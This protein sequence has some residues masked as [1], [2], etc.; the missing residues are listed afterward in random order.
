[1]KTSIRPELVPFSSGRWQYEAV[2]SRV[3]AH[4]GRES[5]LLKGGVASL[6]DSEF[7]DGMIGFDIAFTAE[8]GFVGGVWRL[9]DA[10][11]YEEFYIRPHQSGNPDA[12]QYSPVFNGLSGWQLY[13]GEGFCTPTV[14]PF[15]EWIHVEIV[16]AGKRAEVY[17]E[18]MEEPALVIGELKRRV[19]PGR[20]GLS[21]G[22][23]APAHFSEFTF[24]ALEEPPLKGEPTE[25]EPAP[26]GTIMSWLVSE[27]F[28]E[29][30]L[31]DRF[32]LDA[33]DKANRSW[34]RLACEPTGLA[35]LARVQGIGLLTNTVFART[36]VVS[37]AEQTKCFSFGFSD[38]V[39]VYFNDRLIY[40]GDDTYCS[41]DYRFLGCIGY[42][43]R[44]YLPLVKG[45][46]AIWMAVSESLG[47]WG[48][49]AMFED[50]EGI[51]IG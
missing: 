16:F 11:N 49:Q 34:T 14:Y 51:E 26:R 44:L 35:N 10:E 29:R 40:D 22:N 6:A 4:L 28:S 50:P 48:I 12:N 18:N 3:E 19:E 2:E 39:M 20:V 1:M 7:T 9:Q 24:A 46:N 27:T 32:W 38:R 30:S 45:E 43:D 47:G 5:L 37:R 36:T 13:H 15:D 23:F 8:R 33:E 17:I 41:R 31:R 21:A 25:P 42:F